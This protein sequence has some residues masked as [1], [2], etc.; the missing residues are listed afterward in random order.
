MNMAQEPGVKNLQLR[1][2]L[3][4]TSDQQMQQIHTQFWV[5]VFP[6]CVETYANWRRTDYPK[7]IPANYPGNETGGV[8]PRRLVYLLDEKSLNTD[9]YNAAVEVQG[10]DLML[11]RVWWDRP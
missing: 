9:N 8:I 10:P 3:L 11:T 4:Q 7:L 2:M 5:S 6:N 1:E